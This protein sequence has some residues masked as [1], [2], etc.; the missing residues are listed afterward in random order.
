MADDV[1]TEMPVGTQVVKVSGY[2]FPGEIRSS[3]TTRAGLLRYVVEAT[4]ADY[5]GMLHIFSPSQIA[6]SPGGSDG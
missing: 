5:A 3:F 6:A 2:S 4:G 1:E